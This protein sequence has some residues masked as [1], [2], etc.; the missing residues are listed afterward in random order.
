[1]QPF[2]AEDRA[3]LAE[4]VPKAQ[5]LSRISR[6]TYQI[7][8]E[9]LSTHQRGLLV[10]WIAIYGERWNVATLADLEQA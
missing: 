8:I 10:R 1:M 2:S 5:R 9:Q 4:L 7:W 3:M 6:T